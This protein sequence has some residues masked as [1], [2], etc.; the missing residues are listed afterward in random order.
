MQPDHE[1]QHLVARF[2]LVCCAEFAR[3]SACACVGFIKVGEFKRPRP[4][5]PFS[6]ST[7]SLKWL[8]SSLY[9][10]MLLVEIAS[11]AGCSTINT[12]AML[13]MAKEKKR[14]HQKLLRV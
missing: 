14:A 8:L 4:S 1:V 6:C 10:V 7:D 2:G 13:K 3:E 5:S 11:I 9:Y 12:A